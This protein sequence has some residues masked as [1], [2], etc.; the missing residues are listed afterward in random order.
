[1][2][3]SELNAA[4]AQRFPQLMQKDAEMAVTEILGAIA[5][6][7]AAGNRVEIR[8]F[9]SFA[10]NY[11]PP[12]TGRNP[13]TGEK[14]AVRGKFVPHFKAGKELRDLVDTSQTSGALLR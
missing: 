2:T 11:R 14:V 6:A 5:T 4:L 1:M 9:G 13:K 7:L 10:L 12:R 8:G 3:R